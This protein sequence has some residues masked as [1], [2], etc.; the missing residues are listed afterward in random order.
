MDPSEPTKEEM[1]EA[2]PAEKKAKLAG[3]DVPAV[4]VQAS[5]GV[6]DFEALVMAFEVSMEAE[7]ADFQVKFAEGKRVEEVTEVEA[8]VQ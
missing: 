7:P 2:E 6:P 5:C 8:V 4:K 1:L 3:T